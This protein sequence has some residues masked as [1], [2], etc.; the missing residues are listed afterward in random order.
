MS[1]NHGFDLLATSLAY[2]SRGWPVLP[3]HNPMDGQC[4]CGRDDCDAPA[5]HPRI[6]G[7]FL[8]ATTILDA[9]WPSPGGL[10]QSMQQ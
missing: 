7:G 10:N 3:L 6:Q 1:D 8:S 4:S 9:V 2:A 5:K